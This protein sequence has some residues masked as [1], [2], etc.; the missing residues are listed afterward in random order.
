MCSI[1]IRV[2]NTGVFSAEH[3]LDQ[4]LGTLSSALFEAGAAN[5]GGL[6][7]NKLGKGNISAVLSIPSFRKSG[8]GESS[9]L[10]E[11]SLFLLPSGD[12]TSCSFLCFCVICHYITIMNV[13]L[14]VNITPRRVF[15]PSSY[16]CHLSFVNPVFIWNVF[17]KSF[18]YSLYFFGTGF[19]R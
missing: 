14:E 3:A 12:D 13:L 10:R 5:W 8:G 18:G 19:S 2:F 6:C 11:M 1:K 7:T 17:W 9:S 15:S 4:G 16:N